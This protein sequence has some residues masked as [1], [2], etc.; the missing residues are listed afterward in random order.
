MQKR[1]FQQNSSKI[2]SGDKHGPGVGGIA[3]KFCSDWMSG[4]HFIAQA[5]K[6]LFIKATAVTLSE[7]HGKIIQYISINLYFLSETFKI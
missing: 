3:I 2:S 5:S 6:F 4:S 7:D 1:R